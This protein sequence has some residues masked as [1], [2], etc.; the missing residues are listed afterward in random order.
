MAKRDVPRIYI[1]SDG[2]GGT[3][4]H[5][6]QAILTQFEGEDYS[7]VRKANV[8]TAARVTKIVAEASSFQAIIFYTLVSTATREAMK[9]SCEK[10]QVPR[11]DLFGTPLLALH[12]LFHRKPRSKPGLLYE[13]DRGHFDRLDAIDYTLKHDD[14]SRSHELNRAHVVLAGV[15][16]ASKSSTCFFLAY[17]GIRAA[18]VPLIPNQPV[19]PALL[20]LDPKKVIGLHIN[21][22]RLRNVREV[23]VKTFGGEFLEDY[24]DKRE[25]AHEVIAAKKLMDEH[26]WRSI[27]TSY[28]A[29]EEI[30]KAVIKLAELR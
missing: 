18:N 11:A 5:L 15:S 17:E 3:C 23:R 25:V 12:D 1:I 13:Q 29:I 27:D 20:K 10:M 26:G 7:L 16:R 9:T 2:R 28:M 21:A 4:E 6:V 19:P 24:L 30:A 22:L 8:R 14:G